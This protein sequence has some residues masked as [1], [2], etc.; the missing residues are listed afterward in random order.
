[1]VD[2]APMKPAAA[3]SCLTTHAASAPQMSTVSRY[4]WP[5]IQWCSGF[6]R[7]PRTCPGVKPTVPYS[8]EPQPPVGQLQSEE[9]LGER[10]TTASRPS[11]HISLS[12]Q[13]RVPHALP[14]RRASMSL[15][16]NHGER[17]HSRVREARPTASASSA[18]PTRLLEGLAEHAQVRRALQR[19]GPRLVEARSHGRAKVDG[20]DVVRRV[21]AARARSV[22]AAAVQQIRAAHPRSQLRCTIGG[23][24][25]LQSAGASV[26]AMDSKDE[27]TEQPNSEAKVPCWPGP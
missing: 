12:C 15:F 16:W 18:Y 9:G 4:R 10:T 2:Q 5:A 23:A 21:C 27:K 26:G 14:L 11:P 17:R 8:I 20:H 3:P 24:C 22:A 19:L 1:M 7:P 6:Q 13:V 25:A